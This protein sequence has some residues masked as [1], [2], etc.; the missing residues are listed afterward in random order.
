M[1]KLAFFMICY[2]QKSMSHMTD[3][4]NTKFVNDFSKRMQDQRQTSSTTSTTTLTLQ[5][6]F[7][8]THAIDS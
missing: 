2:A 4:I 1:T 5:D 7:R 6:M 8:Q 3:V